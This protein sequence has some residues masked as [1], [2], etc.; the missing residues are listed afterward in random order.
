MANPFYLGRQ[1]PLGPQRATPADAQ[2]GSWRCRQAPS[3]S[4]TW[5]LQ[6]GRL[7]RHHLN[8]FSWLTDYHNATPVSLLPAPGIPARK[9]GPPTAKSSSSG[10]IAWIRSTSD[11]FFRLTSGAAL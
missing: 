4:D 3:S 8:V 1:P 9:P 7:G 2:L 6:R 5:L 11:H 10:V